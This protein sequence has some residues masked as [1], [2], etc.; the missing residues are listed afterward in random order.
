M[1]RE[2]TR[3]EV[4]HP[5]LIVAELCERAGLTEEEADEYRLEL[6]AALLRIGMECVE[7]PWYARLL[8]GV[9]RRAGIRS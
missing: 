6:F 3:A 7:R 5:Q 4:R 9:R 8:R 2:G 1:L